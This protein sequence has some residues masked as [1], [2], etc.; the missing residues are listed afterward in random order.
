MQRGQMHFKPRK[1]SKSTE[2]PG[3]TLTFKNSLK[4]FCSSVIQ[5]SGLFLIFK[6]PDNQNK[7]DWGGIAHVKR[8]DRYADTADQLAM[9][10]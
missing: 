6:N 2:S 3:S 5:S 8:T 10:S 7:C 4:E 1:I 9:V